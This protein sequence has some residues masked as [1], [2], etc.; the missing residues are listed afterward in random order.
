MYEG[1]TERAQ[2]RLSSVSWINIF[3]EFHH[4]ATLMSQMQHPNLVTLLGV[5][6][7]SLSLVMEYIPGGIL[8]DI[9]YDSKQPDLPYLLK[10]K[11][12]LDVSKALSSMHGMCPPILHRDLRSFNVFLVSLDPKAPV[13]AKV[14]DF[15]LSISCPVTLNQILP[16]W[17]WVSPEIFL[18]E[19]YG[20]ESDVYSFGMV[21]YEIFTRTL[22]YTEDKEF[23]LETE[24]KLSESELSDKDFLNAMEKQ[25]I[26]VYC[27]QAKAIKQEFQIQRA[28]AA[29]TQGH[30]PHLSTPIPHQW[31]V[32]MLDC[33]NCVTYLRPN[34]FV[35]LERINQIFSD[36]L[37]DGG[38]G[39]IENKLTQSDSRAAETNHQHPK[40]FDYPNPT[41]RRELNFLEGQ[42]TNPLLVS[43]TTSEEEMFPV[44][45]SYVREG[46][47]FKVAVP[48]VS[49]DKVS[50]V[51]S[52]RQ[53]LKNVPT[54]TW[55][56]Y[57][58]GTCG[59]E[60]PP[61]NNDTI[62][63]ES[64]D[65]RRKKLL[66]PTTTILEPGQLSSNHQAFYHAEPGQEMQEQEQASIQ[67]E[68][69]VQKLQKQLQQQLQK[70]LQQKI[71][72]FQGMHP[73]QHQ[74]TVQHR[75][76]VADQPITTGDSVMRRTITM[77]S[78]NLPPQN[79][80][81]VTECEGI[82][83]FLINSKSVTRSLENLIDIDTNPLNTIKTRT[84]R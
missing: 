17:Q 81:D 13:V 69:F 83:Y 44:A 80:L 6:Q 1:E 68:Y 43:N 37:D 51:L 61:G 76:V 82:S 71:Q 22:P 54:G 12:S 55:L 53:E 16:T 46:S 78:L 74:L 34:F 64:I 40:V 8:G 65:S 30:R 50:K 52:P 7:S 77:A 35:V 59:K 57:R 49:P 26:I 11:I 15:G 20:R 4:E 47:H 62:E 45:G 31:K 41:R 66:N 42:V 67:H 29:I 18:G 33:W 19:C 36:C 5:Q 32:L 9:L 38:C 72:P 10:V 3:R 58:S 28:K 2:K 25:G 70:Q 79:N 60:I 56:Y 48:A 23:I 21:L 14:G 24:F 73:Q 39:P 75:Q 84:L 27:E 63:W